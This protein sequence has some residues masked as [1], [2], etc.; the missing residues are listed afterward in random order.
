M[1]KN[2]IYHRVLTG[3]TCGQLSTLI[4]RVDL[5]HSDSA[6]GL[7]S[8]AELEDLIPA[9]SARFLTDDEK[10]SIAFNICLLRELDSMG[11]TFLGH[12]SSIVIELAIAVDKLQ[13]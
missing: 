13:N 11:A 3:I 4:S 5:L 2:P 8:E 7:L 9:D 6:T 1:K 10:L 12:T